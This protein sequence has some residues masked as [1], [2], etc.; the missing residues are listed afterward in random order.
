MFNIELGFN[1][2]DLKVDLVERTSYNDDCRSFYYEIA[3]RFY[4]LYVDFKD[5]E[6]R[7]HESNPRYM[8]LGAVN[9]GDELD[10]EIYPLDYSE[11]LLRTDC[12]RSLINYINA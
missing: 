5:V 10:R 9:E 7:E 4:I 12:T 3:G 2:T 1:S 8:V 11:L 6:E